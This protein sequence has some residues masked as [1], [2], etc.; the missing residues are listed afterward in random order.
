MENVFILTCNVSLEYEKSE[1]NAEII[2]KNAKDRERMAAAERAFIDKRLKA[3][4]DL[5]NLVCGDDKEK[6]FMVINQKG[7]DPISLDT[8]LDWTWIRETP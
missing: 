7:I 5:K 4:I 6:N 3:I 2:I 1:D 8:L